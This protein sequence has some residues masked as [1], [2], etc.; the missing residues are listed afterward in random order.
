MDPPSK[1]MRPARKKTSHKNIGR[2]REIVWFEDSSVK[3]MKTQTHYPFHGYTQISNEI[4][5]HHQSSKE[6]IYVQNSHQS[7]KRVEDFVNFEDCS[8]VYCQNSIKTKEPAS[9]YMDIKK[10]LQKSNGLQPKLLQKDNNVNEKLF[11]RI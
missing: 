10:F 2:H 11:I 8:H 6:N 3:F 4:D 9:F 5:S 7:F 1:E